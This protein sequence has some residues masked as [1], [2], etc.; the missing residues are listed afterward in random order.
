MLLLVS[1]L[2]CLFKDT[3]GRTFSYLSDGPRTISPSLFSLEQT[4]SLPSY[5]AETIFLSLAVCHD[6]LYS[7]R[8]LW[9]AS[10]NEERQSWIQAINGATIG[11]SMSDRRCK[12]AATGNPNSLSDAVGDFELFLKIQSDIYSSKTKESFMSALSSIFGSTLTAPIHWIKD[13]QQHRNVMDTPAYTT[14][15]NVEAAHE[16]DDNVNID[17]DEPAENVSINNGSIIDENDYFW[18]DLKKESVYINGFVVKGDSGWGPERIVGALTRSILDFDRSQQ[19]DTGG[20][21]STNNNHMLLL[22]SRIT[23]VQAIMFARDILL[24]CSWRKSEANCHSC[25]STLCG[26]TDLVALCPTN[27]SHNNVIN[28][29]IRSPAKK[30]RDDSVKSGWIASRESSKKPWRSRFCMLLNGIISFY[31]K[32]HP[33]PHGLLEQIDLSGATIGI[34]EVEG[35]KR[36]LGVTSNSTSKIDT[37][38]NK[39]YL[40]CIVPKD[41]TKERQMCFDDQREF[42]AWQE[43]L[44]N[45]ISFNSNT[46]R[47]DGPSS[48]LDTDT[49]TSIMDRRSLLLASSTGAIKGDEFTAPKSPKNQLRQKFMGNLLS[50]GQTG[51]GREHNTTSSVTSGG[52]SNINQRITGNST[53]S[54]VEACVQTSA[55]YRICTKSPIGN[56]K[57]DTWAYVL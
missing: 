16:D 30:E 4:L 43:S 32:E 10:S 54:T 37:A 26:K 40:I 33:N 53:L 20:F 19:H 5:F 22:D 12:F 7:F 56:D 8:R 50:R 51:L 45:A 24:A 47:L 23:E 3:Q 9:M 57:K 13:Q 34:S 18:K 14:A 28:I 35:S 42:L 49:T 21:S 27:G 6:I 29:T 52:T 15:Q 46:N 55:V 36:N 11:G 41:R 2:S 44:N 1:C 25:I 31:E 17:D 39:K 48:L 38:N